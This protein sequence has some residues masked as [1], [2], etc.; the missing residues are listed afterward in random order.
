MLR[1][2][3]APEFFNINYFL[4]PFFREVWGKRGVFL[5]KLRSLPKKQNPQKPLISISL[6]CKELL[7]FWELIMCVI[8][9][10]TLD[11]SHYLIDHCSYPSA[12][13]DW[14]VLLQ[15]AMT[16]FILAAPLPLVTCFPVSFGF[17]RDKVS[18]CSPDILE[19]TM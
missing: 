6:V 19:F 2:Y 1:K 14:E 15:S 11:Y 18:L 9:I 12:E 16:T 17:L 5:S 7:F 8:N 3:S 10:M 13:V 4:Q